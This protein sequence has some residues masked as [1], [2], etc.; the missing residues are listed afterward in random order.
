[1]LFTLTLIGVF[2]FCLILIKAAD[3]VIVAIRRLSGSSGKAFAISAV[4]LAAG[5][6]FPEFAVAITSA[7]SGIPEVSLGTSLGSNVVN[8]SLVAGFAAVMVGTIHF[9]NGYIKK[10][11]IA[12][13]LAGILPI[14]LMLDSRLTRVDGLI[15]LLIYGAYVASFFRDRVE[16]IAKEHR[17][18]SFVY[19]FFRQF[20]HITSHKRKEITRLLIAV[21]VM[22]FS[23][24]IVVRIA[25][26]LAEQ[27]SIPAFV[28]GL[29]FVAIGTSLPELAFS[30]RTLTDR[31]PSM[32]VGNLVG[33]TVANS[34]LIVGIAAT[35]TP[36]EGIVFSK[37]ITATLFFVAIYGTFWFLTK[38][39]MRLDR[40]ESFLLIALYIAFLVTE[41]S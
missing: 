20:N 14:F 22:L 34:T 4:I 12:G 41:F 36:I 5:T 26:Y 40:W 6:S 32:F 39:K 21:S 16:Q 2:L 15:L 29:V 9:G 35:I 8:M 19:K 37:Y 3:H 24:E 25:N 11:M 7:L 13:L 10:E 27:I 38:S 23:A 1:M 17:E 18:E 33:S 28:V 31:E 30:F